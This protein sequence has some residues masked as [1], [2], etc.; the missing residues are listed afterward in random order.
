VSL[1]FT[2]EHISYQV[3]DDKERYILVSLRNI[4]YLVLLRFSAALALLEGYPVIT[5]KLNSARSG[6]NCSFEF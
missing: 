3:L 1:E 6:F 5:A 2:K 4:C